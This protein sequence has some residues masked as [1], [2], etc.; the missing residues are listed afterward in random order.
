[1]LSYNLLDHRSQCMLAGITEHATTS[2]S[3]NS[4]PSEGRVVGSKRAR[5]KRYFGQIHHRRLISPSEGSP[6]LKTSNNS[7]DDIF[8]EDSSPSLSSSP[9]SSPVPTSSPSPI[10][11]K[12][13]SMK[14]QLWR[15]G[16]KLRPI[17]DTPLWFQKLYHYRKLKKLYQMGDSPHISSHGS[18]NREMNEMFEC[19][20]T[21]YGKSYQ[22]EC[23]LSDDM[24]NSASVPHYSP[25]TT[26]SYENLEELRK[27]I[28]G[29]SY[30]DD[31]GADLQNITRKVSLSHSKDLKDLH[32]NELAIKGTVIEELAAPDDAIPTPLTLSHPHIGVTSTM[33]NKISENNEP[34]QRV[35]ILERSLSISSQRSNRTESSS[36]SSFSMVTINI[37]TM[38]DTHFIACLSDTVS[39]GQT[40][41]SIYRPQEL[42]CHQVMDITNAVA[43]FTDCIDIEQDENM[44]NGE[45]S[46]KFDMF[47]QLMLYDHFQRLERKRKTSHRKEVPTHLTTT[48]ERQEFFKEKGTL[49]LFDANVS[50]HKNDPELLHLSRSCRLKLPK[51]CDVERFKMGA[52]PNKKSILKT[53]KNINS[54]AEILLAQLCDSVPIESFLDLV[55]QNERRKMELLPSLGDTRYSQVLLYYDQVDDF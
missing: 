5:L 30:L 21:Y 28:F 32:E 41:Q 51:F 50:F 55:D 26:L 13:L 17:S 6:I 39:E 12:G 44:K 38:R 4:S 20:R 35:K 15:T 16:W 19:Y 46:I 34:T 23:P 33:K 9:L 49:K 27:E 43:S 7:P 53:K 3:L 18:D 45:P 25:L 10:H 11:L 37:P 31:F 22:D 8:D 48:E 2:D 54:E 14:L 1:M 52:V 24:V 29:T 42:N 36:S 40:I 47:A